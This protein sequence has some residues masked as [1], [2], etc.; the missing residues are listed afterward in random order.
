MHK[1][2]ATRR[3]QHKEEPSFGWVY[4]GSHN[5]SAAAWGRPLSN[6]LDKIANLRNSSV[7]GSRLHVCNYELGII[8]TVPPPD[9]KGCE[10]GKCKDLDDI[11]LPFVIPAPKYRAMDS[12]ATP[13]AMREALVELAHLEE[14]NSAAVLN[15]E[16]P[17]EEVPDE[18]DE[19]VLLNTA[20]FVAE[21]K[22]D[23][24]AYADKLWIQVDSSE[25]C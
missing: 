13:Q 14:I 5:F 1:Q 21:E 17:A 3:F 25:S 23:E 7:L 18:E 9:G 20:D 2:V 15:G 11:P 16:C 8:F 10:N 4:S 22:E 24:K 12:P 6:T 19:E